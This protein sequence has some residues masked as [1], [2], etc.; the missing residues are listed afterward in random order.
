MKVSIIVP[1]KNEPGI[2][3]LVKEI[4]KHLA[5]MNHEIIVVD[6]S[7]VPPKI[8]GVK[9]IRQ[10]SDGL[11]KAILEGTQAARGDVIVVM[12]ADFSHRPQDIKR[13][14]EKAKD[15]DIVIGSRFVEGG[16]NTDKAHRKLVSMLLRKITSF[17]LGLHVEDNMSGFSAM[18]SHVYKKLKLNPIGYKINMEILYKGKN[19]GLKIAE[20]PIVFHKRMY[21]KSKV[22]INTSGLKEFFRILIYMMKLKIGMQ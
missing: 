12:D 22:G 19:A 20:V 9:L 18:R 14:V 16:R 11:G 13:L 17:V 21:G 6:K 15:Y 1:T 3:K 5:K 7:D 2:D 8:K 10:K 4:H